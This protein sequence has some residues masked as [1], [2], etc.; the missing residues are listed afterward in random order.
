MPRCPLDVLQLL[1]A[2]AVLHVVPGH[3]CPHLLGGHVFTLALY[4]AHGPAVLVQGFGGD[5][6]ALLETQV[7]KMLLRPLAECLA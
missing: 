7:R 2:L 4:V 1:I 5:G 3:A 6:R